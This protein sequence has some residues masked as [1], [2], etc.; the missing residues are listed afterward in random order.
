MVGRWPDIRIFELIAKHYLLELDISLDIVTIYFKL[1]LFASYGAS[2]LLFHP[3]MRGE[4]LHSHL[5]NVIEP[6]S[7]RSRI[8]LPVM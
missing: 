7:P 5:R 1:L 2:V 6:F 4:D 8:T 3:L